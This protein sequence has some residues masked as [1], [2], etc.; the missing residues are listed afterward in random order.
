MQINEPHHAAGPSGPRPTDDFR[1]AKTP[2]EAAKQFEEIL[3]R[4]FVKT[5]TDGL[6]KTSLA[7][8]DGP[9]WME[10]Y[11]NTQRDVL[12]D[13][14][15]KHLVRSGTLRLSDLLL[16][17]WTGAKAETDETTSDGTLP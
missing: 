4:Q 17:Q 14:L 2:E 6:F 15:T 7:G 1:R 8:E 10:S 3:A 16:R 11:Q 5:M 13:E 9:G 12:T